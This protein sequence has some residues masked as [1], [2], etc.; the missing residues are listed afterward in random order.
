LCTQQ[1]VPRKTTILKSTASNHPTK[2]RMATDRR[3]QRARCMLQHARSQRPRHPAI[4]VD[5]HGSIPSRDDFFLFFSCSNPSHATSPPQPSS[6]SLPRSL[7]TGPSLPLDPIEIHGCSPREL[8]A[9]CGGDGSRGSSRRVLWGRQ[10]ARPA[11]AS[12]CCRVFATKR[13]FAKPNKELHRTEKSA[14]NIV[15]EDMLNW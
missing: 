11:A 14:K 10:G 1:Y 8:P 4:A 3:L 13:I 9:C 15:Y 6:S 5:A 12:T 7:L 2:H